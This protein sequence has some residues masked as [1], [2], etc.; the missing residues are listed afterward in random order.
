MK[1]MCKQAQKRRK[2]IDERMKIQSEKAKIDAMTDQ[3]RKEYYEKIQK[4]GMD[5]I[6]T[7][8]VVNTLR[9]NFGLKY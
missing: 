7:L 8:G 6:K 3:E 1:C 9:S 4:H 2:E 5:I